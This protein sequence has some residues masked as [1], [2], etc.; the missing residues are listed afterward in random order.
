MTETKEPF[1]LATFEKKPRSRFNKALSWWM[2][3]GEDVI[4]IPV[5]GCQRCGEC[6]LSHTAFICSQRCPKRLRNGP[7]G[8]TRVK[9]RCEVYPERMCVWFR[10]HRRAKWMRRLPL[11]R[12]ISRI[13]NWRLEK[14][15][16]W[17]N[18]FTG[19]ID[20]PVIFIRKKKKRDSER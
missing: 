6:I 19:R 2:L 5:W 9:G 17:L 8:G 18:A 15:A 20:M 1:A 4:K 7:C 11:T 14:T 12:E 13:H 3:L 10:I 16:A